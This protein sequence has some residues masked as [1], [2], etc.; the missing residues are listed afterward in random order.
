MHGDFALH[1]D[2]VEVLNGLGGSLTEQRQGHEQLA[3]PP[4]VLWV[5]GTLKILQGLMKRILEPLDSLDI[6]Y[7]HG[8]WSEKKKVGMTKMPK[9]NQ[10]FHIYIDNNCMFCSCIIWL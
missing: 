4:G 10:M 1:F 9:T 5:L 8:V 2:A 3:C 7:V 6:L